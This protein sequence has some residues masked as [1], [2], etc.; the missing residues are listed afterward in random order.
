[1]AVYY[2]CRKIQ[3]FGTSLALTI[4][5][6]F[7]KVRSVRKGEKVHVIYCLDGVVIVSDI[8]DVNKLISTLQNMIISMEKIV[9][10]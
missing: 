3:E 8:K 7:A 4:P 2:S 6:L 10:P 5:S 9:I 1:M